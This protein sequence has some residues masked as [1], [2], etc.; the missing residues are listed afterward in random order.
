MATCFCVSH[1]TWFIWH[2]SFNPP[3]PSLPH[4][5]PNECWCP[6]TE[7]DS[8]SQKLTVVQYTDSEYITGLSLFTWH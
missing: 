5:W 3:P 4:V 2:F 8:F 1:G 7:T 6:P